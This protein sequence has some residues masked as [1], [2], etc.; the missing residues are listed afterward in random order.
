MNAP[1]ITTTREEQ[2][3]FGMWRLSAEDLARQVEADAEHGLAAEER[4][5]AYFP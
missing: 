2:Q 5:L 3:T 1:I 4:G